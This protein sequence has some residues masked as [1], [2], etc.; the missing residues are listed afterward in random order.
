[1]FGSIT[2]KIYHHYTCIIMIHDSCIKYDGKTLYVKIRDHRTN[3]GLIWSLRDIWR[4]NL[5]KD[6][7]PA[8]DI[9]KVLAIRCAAFA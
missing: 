6:Q 1:M 5:N 8:M 7:T 3:H 4:Q 2:L 9:P